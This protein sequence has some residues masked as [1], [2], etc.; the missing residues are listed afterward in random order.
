MKK[1]GWGEYEPH[2]CQSLEKSIFQTNPEDRQSLHPLWN[3]SKSSPN[4][5]LKETLRKSRLSY[6]RLIYPTTTQ[7]LQATRSRSC[8]VS[9]LSIAK[10]P[11]LWVQANSLLSRDQSYIQ[12][13]HIRW[14]HRCWVQESIL[15]KDVKMLYCIIKT[16]PFMKCNF[17]K[18]T[19]P[20]C[21]KK[22]DPSKNTSRCYHLT[23]PWKACYVNEWEGFK[24]RYTGSVMTQ[25]YLA[26]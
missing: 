23:L 14:M 25:V 4:P 5:T 22:R 18:Q 8:W 2:Q 24:S 20:L 26:V 19:T 11:G 3:P 13:W 1:N 21:E 16:C 10:E 15:Y 9:F 17:P 12:R 6:D 7:S